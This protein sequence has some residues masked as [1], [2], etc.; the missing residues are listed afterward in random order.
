MEL[1]VAVM[2]FLVSGT[3]HAPPIQEGATIQ[4]TT[5]AINK[6][7][8]SKREFSITQKEIKCLEKNLWHEARGENL[9]GL[10]AVAKTTLN[11][12]RMEGWPPDVCKVVYQKSQF[13]WTLKS[14]KN[15]QIK[16][17]NN[18]DKQSYTLVQLATQLS[19]TAEMLQIDF[20]N[21]ATYYHTTS[22]NPTWGRKMEVVSVIGDH[23]FK[24]DKG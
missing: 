5:Q 17:K 6:D 2:L 7:I 9:Y 22:V 24:K 18:I 15:Q 14:K 11:R 10:M 19:I 3:H 16:L 20:M 8:D 4:T 21:G 13:S 1:I 23:I 12:A